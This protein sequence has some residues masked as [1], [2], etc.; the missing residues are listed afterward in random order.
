MN[1]NHDELERLLGDELND[2]AGDMTGA[3]L[4]LGDVRGR[5]TSIRRR[6]RV[7]S[8]VGVAAVLAIAVPL[9]ISVGGSIDT[10][11]QEPAP[12]GPPEISRTTLTLDGLERGDAPRIE[13]FTADGV[14]V[15]G[16]GLQPLD[17]SYQALV[18]NGDTWLA[19]GP[20]RDDLL[21][22]DQDFRQLD[23]QPTNQ[24]LV[25]SADQSQV[26]WTRPEGG[27]QSLVQMRTSGGD[28]SE[29]GFPSAPLV[30][31]VDFVGDG[32]VL[33]QTT[34]ARG[35]HKTIGIASVD[36]ETDEFEGDF[37]KAIA[38]NPETG[39]VTVQTKTNADASG[40]F[41]VVDP[42]VSTSAT[43]WETCDNSLGGFS[44]DGRYVLASSPYGDGLGLSSLEVLDARN[45]APVAS[46]QQESTIAL[47]GVV[48][49]SNDSIIAV[50]NEGPTNTILR[51]GVG[52]TL[53]EAADRVDGDPLA[54]QPYYLGVDR[55]R[56]Y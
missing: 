33:Y 30:D 14:V 34:D 46:F 5:A 26:A 31:P 32:E 1:T 21:W 10:S 18:S 53:E 41:G 47:I 11:K 6:R 56:G 19:L 35:R 37:V 40:C 29:V 4:L 39:L 28:M 3:R 25:S 51:F 16:E 54:D 36:G 13:Y 15:P 12:A 43:V 50:A 20:S 9:A 44:P 48:W 2:R 23:E 8:G 7:A 45:G 27:G 55:R 24:V 52:G 49:E 38:G 42:A 22:L 17:D